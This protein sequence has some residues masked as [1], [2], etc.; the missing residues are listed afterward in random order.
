MKDLIRGSFVPSTLVQRMRQY[1]RRIFDLN[2]EIVYKLTKLDFVLQLCN[3][4]ISNYVSPVDCKSYKEVVR[5]VSEGVTDSN[6]LASVIHE[7]TINRV[8][9]KTITASLTSVISE[10]I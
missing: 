5:L 7:R 2:K 1:N 6:R 8:E 10:V 4:R 9:K 3:I